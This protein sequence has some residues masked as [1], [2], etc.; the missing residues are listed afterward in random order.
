MT[1]Y[2][3]NNINPFAV[4]FEGLNKVQQDAVITT[5]GY[6]RVIAGAGSGKTR[7]LAH[8]YAYIINSLGISPSNIL[9]VTFTNKAANEMRSRVKKLVDI[10]DGEGYICTY[11]GFCVKILREDIP[12]ICYPSSF[13][14]MDVE[15]QKSI[16]RE[17]YNELNLKHGDFTFKDILKYISDKKN[18]VKYNYIQNYIDAYDDKTRQKFIDPK[19]GEDPIRWACF[20][21]YLQKQKKGFFLDFDDLMHYAI[22]IFQKHKDV[23]AKWQNRLDYIMVDETQDNSDKQWYFVSMLQE[24]HKNLF[25]VG[26]PDQCIYEWRG[27][28]PTGLINF[29]KLFG[30]CKTVI[31]NQN[32]R[33]TPNILDAANS[34]IINNKNRIEKEL[35]SQKDRIS[36]VV[37][38]HGTTEVEEGEYIA[39]TIVKYAQ[40]GGRISDVA[41]LYRA[42]YLSRFVEQ[43]LINNELTYTVY[44]GIRFF[45]RKEIKD[46]L[47]YLRMIDAADDLSFKRVI[48]LPSRKLGRVFLSELTD[49][50]QQEG[51]SLYE[52]LKLYINNKELNKS[53]AVE[54]ID[55]IESIKVEVQ[56]KTISDTVQYIL[57]RSKLSDALQQ[58]GDQD[59]VENIKDLIASI[60]LYEDSNSNEEDLGLTRY[61]QDIALY[62]NLDYKESKETVKIMTIHQS[63]GLEFPIVFVV[64]LSEGIFPSPRTLLQRRLAGLEEERRLAYVAFT[65]A[66]KELHLTESEGYNPQSCGFKFPSRFI[67]EIKKEL[68]VREGVLP[69]ELEKEA[70]A[71]IENSNYIASLENE[72]TDDQ[73]EFKVGDKV[74]HRAFGVGEI[75]NVDDECMQLSI[76][77]ENNSSERHI[78]LRR[79]KIVL[80]KTISQ[81]E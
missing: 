2:I 51:L 1:D 8:R 11:H 42:S 16:L 78:E 4:L 15:D 14:I 46:V 62:T 32:Y 6:V 17:V 59:R 41:I 48:N 19:D 7:T 27:A 35:F 72:V 20:V 54:F 26:D 37:H 66:E 75:V 69:S 57:D 63:K 81:S 21:K 47:A 36:N 52:A 44:G 12:K 53:G 60:Q 13:I 71:Y 33:S 34:I 10:G 45:E 50:A 31:L 55:L 67:F 70:I 77:F 29:E 23:L 68:V 18:S 38:F 24:M 28:K 79:A 64:G 3:T 22:Y 43:A 73:L 61:L 76:L 49:I 9:C 30:S 56:N 39:K 58:D 74:E 25:V 5:E 65:R 40:N 80:K